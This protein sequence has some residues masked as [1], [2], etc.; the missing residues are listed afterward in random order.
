MNPFEI[1]EMPD[2]TLLMVRGEVSLQNAGEAL[3]VLKDFRSRSDHL[4]LDLENVETADVSFLQ[5]ICSLHRTC[6]R[7]GQHLTLSEKSPEHFKTI[8]ETS[9]Y[10]RPRACTLGGDNPCLWTWR[11]DA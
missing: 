1:T 5:L 10:R 9:G 6:L 3:E 11:S 2:H 8:L 4:R 7:S